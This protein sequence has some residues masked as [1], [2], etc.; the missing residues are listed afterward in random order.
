[1]LDIDWDE[2]LENLKSGQCVFVLG[3]E[4]FPSVQCGK[5]LSDAMQDLLPKKKE[6]RDEVAFYREDGFFFFTGS[7][8]QTL[9]NQLASRLKK[10]YEP[11][12]SQSKIYEILIEIPALMYISL[13]PDCMINEAFEK[14]RYSY[15][16][17][18][19]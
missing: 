12:A 14:K 11:E 15:V 5:S 13:S 6:N 9:N 19:F 8:S 10:F 4:L 7:L 1:M 16:F 17:D 3:P 18:F 2:I